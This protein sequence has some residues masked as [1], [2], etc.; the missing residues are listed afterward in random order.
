MYMKLTFKILF[1][2][3][4]TLSIYSCRQNEIK[5]SNTNK[6]AEQ[7]AY[8]IV[9]QLNRCWVIPKEFSESSMITEINIELDKNGF[10]TK[11]KPTLIER[12]ETDK[13]FAKFTDATIYSIKK[14]T[15]LKNLP[16]DK[17]YFWQKVDIIFNTKAKI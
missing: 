6:E 5:V 16:K 17:Y 12:Y 13:E 9:K 1:F 10:I 15:P 4:L 11:A 14:C 2:T 7:L 3:I 8:S